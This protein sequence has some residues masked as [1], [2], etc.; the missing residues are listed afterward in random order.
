MIQQSEVPN[1]PAKERGGVMVDGSFGP[2]V[3][4]EME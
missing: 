4:Q 1:C 2:L 3:Y